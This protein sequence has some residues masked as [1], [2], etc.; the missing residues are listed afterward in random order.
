VS[1][2]MVCDGVSGA[3]GGGGDEDERAVV[4]SGSPRPPRR[5]HRG[6]TPVPTSSE[7]SG[8]SQQRGCAAGGGEGMAHRGS[9]D[10]V[11]CTRGGGLQASSSAGGLSDRLVGDMTYGLELGGCA[12]RP[13][14]REEK[15]L[16]RKTL[17]FDGGGGRYGG[18]GAA[19]C[20]VVARVESA[21]SDAEG[22]WVKWEW[23]ILP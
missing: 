6:G 17:G 11:S 19:R 3:G 16:T 21:M 14:P 22:V 18:G 9:S 12:L 10:G 15:P 2:C 20:G 7:A 4:G 23:G 8:R 13:P 1:A 5:Q